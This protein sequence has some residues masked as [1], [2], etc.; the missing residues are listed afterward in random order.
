MNRNV[1]GQTHADRYCGIRDWTV[2]LRF[3]DGLPTGHV[4][5]A[6]N[7]VYN[8][9]RGI[10]GKAR[11]DHHEFIYASKL[12]LIN[13]KRQRMVFHRGGAGYVDPFNAFYGQVLLNDLK[14]S[15][16]SPTPSYDD[17]GKALPL[18]YMGNLYRLRVTQIPQ[19]MLYK[20]QQPGDPPDKYAGSMWRT[21]GDLGA[22]NGG[23]VHYAPL[24][25]SCLNVHGGGLVRAVL[26]ENAPLRLTTL[27]KVELPSW[28]D[29]GIRNGTV[30]M[31][32]VKIMKLWGYIVWAHDSGGGFTPHVVRV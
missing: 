2:P 30:W 25:W 27:P 23:D 10:N 19:G 11:L 31:A 32:F 26:P 8:D 6:F 7:L 24:V 29:K 15:P 17:L 3:P 9:G 21:Y 1:S 16:G 13:G 18:S 28:N 4:I 14:D 20:Q 22:R 5:N 12:P